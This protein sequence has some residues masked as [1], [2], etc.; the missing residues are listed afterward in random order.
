MAA[1][2]SCSAGCNCAA[3]AACG[4]GSAGASHSQGGGG[5]SRSLCRIHGIL[6]LYLAGF[7]LLHLGINALAM[8]PTRYSSLL[9]W[10]HG[11]PDLTK[12]L[13]LIMVS[14]PLTVQIATGLIRISRGGLRG[15]CR[16]GPLPPWAQRLSGLVILL[17]LT[18]HLLLAKVVAPFDVA[19]AVPS[20]SRAVIG[21]TGPWASELGLASLTVI[22]LWAAALHVGNGI[23]TALRFVVSRPKIQEQ[24][25]VRAICTAIGL[26]L[27]TAGFCGWTALLVQ[28]HG[29]QSAAVAQPQHHEHR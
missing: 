23:L 14:L 24:P 18:I 9:A 28:S 13:S 27:V 17:F 12:I 11:R 6:G 29:V 16:H 10:L 2:N 15:H 5:H 26:V 8:R 4:C 3:G 25:A 20:A 1:E 7:V 21:P 19:Q 22:A